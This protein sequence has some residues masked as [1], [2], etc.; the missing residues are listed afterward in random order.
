M[1]GIH[2]IGD[3]HDCRCPP[4]LLLDPVGLQRFCLEA[5][6]RN[7]LTVVGHLFHPFRD[8][9]GGSAGVTGAVVLAES[10]LA[11]HTWPEIATVT[12]DVYVCNYSSD[13]S[14]RAQALFHDLV[15]HFQPARTERLAVN[16]GHLGQ[17][18]Q[19]IDASSAA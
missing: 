7:Q 5:C 8:A 1:H 13:N 6:Q 16:R 14:T 3:L 19:V 4:E 10:H 9:S 12:L 18:E 11:I 2:L 15:A 17:R